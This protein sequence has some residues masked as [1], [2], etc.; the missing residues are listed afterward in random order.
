MTAGGTAAT[1]VVHV[2]RHG[3]VDNPS[4]ILYGRLPGYRLSALGEQMAVA[5]AAALAERDITYLVASPLERA[6]QT[7]APLAAKLGLPVD[8][9]ER[10]IE[11]ENYFEG[12]RFGVGDGVLRNP[13]NWWLLRNPLRPSWGEPYRLIA[14][15]MDLALCS[16]RDQAIG[17]EAVCVSHQLP[18]WTLRRYRS[19][20]RLWHDPRRRQCALASITSFRFDGDRLAGIEY[21]EPAAYLVATSP[22][23]EQAKG[24]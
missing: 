18:V 7:A 11:S 4:K 1:T 5:V 16:A 21:S 8:T 19:G 15:R 6:Q 14:A 9:D 12:Q 17:H 20:Q 3:E 2:V 23:A 10:L 22:G 24:A 13:R